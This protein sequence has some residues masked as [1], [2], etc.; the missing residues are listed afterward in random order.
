MITRT[1]AINHVAETVNYWVALKP[2]AES[3]DP[4]LKNAIEA[5]VEHVRMHHHYPLTEE[6][7]TVALAKVFQ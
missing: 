6:D 1:E 5:A 3:T 7:I 4:L 2:N